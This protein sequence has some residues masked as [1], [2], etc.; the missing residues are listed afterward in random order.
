MDKRVGQ[1]IVEHKKL[2]LLESY[3]N[4]VSKLPIA[5]FSTLQEFEIE[6]LSRLKQEITNISKQIIST[7]NVSAS[8]NID[9]MMSIDE[10]LTGKMKHDN[11]D[12]STPDAQE[13]FPSDLLLNKLREVFKLKDFRPNQINVLEATLRGN[14]CFVIMPT[15]A[16]KS[17]CYQL[18]AIITKG[19]TI[20][21]SPLTSLIDD[22][23]FKLSA[24]QVRYY[25]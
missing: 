15:G 13:Y 21:I 9:S 1:S 22:Q 8:N 25:F 20:V 3:Y 7:T 4:I 6:T 14:N 2:C 23:I 17:L 10:S 16:G 18:P 5:S 24:L 19:V 12:R 11:N